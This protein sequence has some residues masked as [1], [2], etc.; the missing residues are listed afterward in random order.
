MSQSVGDWDYFLTLLRFRWSS[1][2]EYIGQ[3]KNAFCATNVVLR[4]ISLEELS[5]LIEE[6]LTENEEE[7]LLDIEETPFQ[8]YFSDEEIWHVLSNL[9]GKTT[10]AEFQQLSPHTCKITLFSSKNRL[11]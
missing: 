11:S 9:C 10:S 2:L 6:P 8:T 1:W 7:G 4:R 5:T 3:E